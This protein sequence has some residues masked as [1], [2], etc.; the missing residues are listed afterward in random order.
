MFKIRFLNS[1]LFLLIKYSIFFFIIAFIG[2]RFKSAVLDNAGTQF[3][4]FKLTFGYVFYV[5]IYSV[6]LIALFFSPLYFI[7]KIEKG[8][9]FLLAIAVFY[10]VEFVVYSYL[11]SPSDLTLGFYNATVGGVLLFVFFGR[12]I[13]L[14]F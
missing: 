14:K 10:G 9:L 1:I 4:A 6:L 7:L 12:S 5:L 2:G 11:Y 13:K 3:E 8:Y